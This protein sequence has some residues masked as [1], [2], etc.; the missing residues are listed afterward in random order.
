MP[1]IFN[2][3]EPWDGIPVVG[4]DR[5]SGYCSE[6]A[7]MVSINVGY[8]YYIRLVKDN[9]YGAPQGDGT[10]NGIIGELIRHVRT[11]MPVKILFFNILIT[12]C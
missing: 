6:L 9:T 12:K 8:E 5:F 10:W 2:R 7:D 11:E 4:R 1:Y 3:T